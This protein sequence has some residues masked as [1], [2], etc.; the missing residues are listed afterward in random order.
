MGIRDHLP[1]PS[2]SPSSSE[3]DNGEDDPLGPRAQRMV[4][5]F[6]WKDRAYDDAW[7]GEFT[8]RCGPLV[9][10]EN[11]SIFNIFHHFIDDQLLQ[12]I[13]VETNR[14]AERIIAQNAVYTKTLQTRS[15][16]VTAW[17]DCPTMTSTQIEAP[18]QFLPTPGDPVIPWLQWRRLFENYLLASNTVKESPERRSAI[19]LHSLGPEGQRI[20]YT[21]PE[22]GEAGDDI[23]TKAMTTLQSHFAPKVS[24]VAERYRF[25]QRAQLPHESVD[26]YIAALRELASRCEFGT[27]ENEMLRDQLVEKTNSSKI[28]TRL[29]T[30]TDVKLD[31]AI[32]LARQCE[33]AM[34]E[35]KSMSGGDTHTCSEVKYKA[36]PRGAKAEFKKEKQRPRP[37]SNAKCYR[38][39]SPQH[40]ANSP[41]C[42]AGSKDCNSCGKKGHL[43]SVCRGKRKVVKQV[44]QADARGETDQDGDMIEV[45]CTRSSNT[46]SRKSVWGT[47]KV[48]SINIQMLVDTASDVS[49]LS[50]KLF[51]KYFVRDALK[52]CIMP[53]TSYT[54]H[55]ITTVGCF[56]A[57]VQF[58]SKCANATFYVVTKGSSLIGKD[59]IQA[60]GINIDGSTLTCFETHAEST[61]TDVN[62]QFS[63]LFS[64]TLG[65]VKGFKHKVKVRPEVK[66]VQQKLRR[67]PLTVRQAVSA[68]LQRLLDAGIIE[69]AEAPE[70]VSP[71]VVAWKKTGK[72]RIFVDLRKPNE[73]VIEDKFPLPSIEEMLSEMNGATYFS[74]LDLK[75]A[76]YQLELD[77]DSRDLT[78]FITHD[79][80]FRFRTVCFG[81]S[82]APSC[83][84]KMMSTV[85][86][87]IPNVQCFIDDIII[88]GRDK[89]AHDKTLF[90]VLTR[91]KERGMTLNDK[92][93]FGVPSMKVLGHVIDD[94]GI[95][96]SDELV[97]GIAK[98]AIP[99]TNLQLKSFLGL[100]G[101]YARFVPNFSAKECL[102]FLKNNI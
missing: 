62:S 59:L 43:S 83:F 89:A 12:L 16:T 33:T 51:D 4:D 34:K 72:I 20:F 48:N 100:A 101:F 10:D 25:R 97:H 82:S 75:S 37:N 71:I 26:N 9:H 57:K 21:L 81:L 42:T 8:E 77:S 27:F 14:Y 46:D 38:C 87:G 79:D 13:V 28:R 84:Q 35:A 54:S 30:E 17:L 52:P 32:K 53:I 5:R 60:L 29:L 74:K 94:K 66:P 80:V 19:L 78:S 24:V 22:L 90:S 55:K 15:T 40:L 63:C 39:G 31:K 56:K 7:L 47:L 23:L 86:A 98:A 88:Y 41:E 96:P 58:K 76:Y 93:E 1:I 2:P 11:S 69:R 91:L 73:A 102:K 65:K 45:L 18:V 64:D 6:K 3:E 99:Q 68:E 70:W 67:L 49:L 61:C 95:H 36:K 44:E 92:C 50:L 85:L